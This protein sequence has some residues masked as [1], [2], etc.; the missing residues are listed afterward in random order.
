MVEWGGHVICEQL[1]LSRYLYIQ[2]GQQ[3]RLQAHNII[4]INNGDGTF[5][6]SARELD[7]IFQASPHS[8]LS[9]IKEFVMVIWTCFYSITLFTLYAATGPLKT[10]RRSPI[11]WRSL[12][13]NRLNEAEEKFVDVTEASGIYSS[14]LGYGL[15]VRVADINSDGWQDLYVGNDFHENDFIYLN[16]Q[17]KTFKEAVEKPLT[18][19]AV[20]MGPTLLIS[21]TMACWTFFPLT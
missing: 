15:A 5:T 11:K 1:W 20:Y 3:Q 8:P 19:V 10:K 13:E 9:L 12:Y 14:P 7:L 17:N 6:E 2:S 18:T 4:Y 16:Q 21:T